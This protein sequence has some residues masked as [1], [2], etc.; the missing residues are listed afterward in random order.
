MLKKQA[1]KE[2]PGGETALFLLGGLNRLLT[3]L[4]FFISLTVYFLYFYRS[5]IILN[6]SLPQVEITCL[7]K[8]GIFTHHY[9][10][11][12]SSTRIISC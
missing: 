5:N 6:I 9:I 10:T 3:R 8:T 4:F 7:G 12:S 1:G 11:G 2:S